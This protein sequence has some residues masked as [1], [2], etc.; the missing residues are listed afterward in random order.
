M[1]KSTKINKIFY[2]STKDV[3]NFSKKIQGSCVL[4]AL[5]FY[6]QNHENHEKADFAIHS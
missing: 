4:E 6:Q 3:S 2:D 1:F 5:D